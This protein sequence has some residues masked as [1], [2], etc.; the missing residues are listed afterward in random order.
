M[1]QI[2]QNI[3]ENSCN[4][5]MTLLLVI[6]NSYNIVAARNPCQEWDLRFYIMLNNRER[7]LCS[8]ILQRCLLWPPPLATVKLQN[9]AA[10]IWFDILS[11]L[12]INFMMEDKDNCRGQ[13]WFREDAGLLI[14]CFFTTCRRNH[15]VIPF[16]LEQGKM[17]VKCTSIF[18]YCL[19]SAAG[20]VISVLGYFFFKLF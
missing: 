2:L 15:A 20:R 13:Q 4:E 19:P 11:H 5:L 10:F 18:K 1:E 16:G 12:C 8:F 7:S 6:I 3:K 17:T 14:Y 9:W